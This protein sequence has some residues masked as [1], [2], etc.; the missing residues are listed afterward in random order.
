MSERGLWIGLLRVFMEHK[1]FLNYLEAV[2]RTATQYYEATSERH[3]K[4]VSELLDKFN[5]LIQKNDMTIQDG[6]ITLSMFVA[7]L[8]LH[9]ENTEN[10]RALWVADA[11]WL[12]A[13]NYLLAQ[14][15]EK[16]SLEKIKGM[17]G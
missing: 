13:T 11:V 3:E 6:I 8:S 17:A 10:V 12:L 15:L 16:M 7:Y 4:I 2:E 1:K 9:L 5:E 14:E